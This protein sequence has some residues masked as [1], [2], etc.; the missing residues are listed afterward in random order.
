MKIREARLKDQKDITELYYQLYPKRRQKRS[1]PIK[2]F[3]AK[4]FLLVAEKKKKIIGFI[5][6]TFI[7]YGTSKFGYIEELFVK[8]EFRNKGIGTTLVKN[9][10]K[11]MKKL[12][13]AALF[14][15]TEKENREAIKLYRNLGFK[16]C[17]G[18][19]LYWN[20]K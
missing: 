2:K 13:I 19:W 6:S 14:V 15:T 10:M 3:N 12:K 7:N 9:I 17:K 11:K 16:K 4:S 5:W 8:K 20:P 1:L 18:S